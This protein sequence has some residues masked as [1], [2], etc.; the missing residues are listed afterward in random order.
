MEPGVD[1]ERDD[2]VGA[3]EEWRYFN[4]LHEVGSNEKVQQEKKKLD[5]SKFVTERHRS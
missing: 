1:H 2:P 5:S 3:D 4:K